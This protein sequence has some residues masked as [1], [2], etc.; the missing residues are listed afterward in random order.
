[1][2]T[3]HYKVTNMDCG[4]CAMHIESL[5]DEITGVDAIKVSYKKQTMEVKF[6]E[7][8]TNLDEINKRVKALGYGL[9]E[10]KPT[11]K[12]GLFSWIRK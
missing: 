12:K 9:T 4:S 10:T 6:D 8:K 3:K 11:G 2:T 1:M 5:E 7:H